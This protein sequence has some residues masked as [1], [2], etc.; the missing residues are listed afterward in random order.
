M[1][2]LLWPLAAFGGRSA[3]AAFIF[4]L[5][6][7]LLAVVLRATTLAGGQSRS[8]DRIVLIIG[9]GTV[10]PTIPL[11]AAVANLLSPRAAI[12]RQELALTSSATAWTPLSIDEAST[13]WAS[14]VVVGTIAVFFAARTIVRSGGLRQTVRGISALGFL[15]SILALAQAATA[16]RLIYWRFPTEYEGPLPFGPFVNRNHFAT[17]IIMAAPVC[18]GY[19]IARSS[20]RDESND[21]LVSKRTR[22]AKMADGRMVWLAGAGAMMLA[23]LLASMSRSGILA[24]T[25]AVG[26]FAVAHRRRSAV[27]RVGWIVAVVV[28]IV[29]FA[30]ARADIPALAERFSQAGT[31]VRDRVKIWRDTVP[32][33]KDFWLVGTGAG[34]YRSAMLVYQ[35]ADRNVQFNQGH[36]H[37]LQAAAEGGT[38]LVSLLA[39]LLTMLVQATRRQLA[40]DSSGAY[41]IRAG[42]ACGLLAVALQSLWETGLVMPA[43]A[44]LAAVLAA[45]A[46]Y[47]R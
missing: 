26:W 7:L 40:V 10:I 32:V 34:T 14:V 44:A 3:G 24:L 39:A 12:V 33:V 9:I 6:S 8:L 28:L 42:A 11:P 18:F 4:A 31:G 20:G 38:V 22:L 41:W 19:F 5:T 47:E 2:L 16:G 37:Y 17:W 29:G 46:A 35:R 15:F 25:G 27:R 23:A 13:L 21:Q 43:N 45:I 1:L 36:N 30:L